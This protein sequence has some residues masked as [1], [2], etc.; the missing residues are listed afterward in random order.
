M[1]MEGA[2][3]SGGKKFFYLVA[4]AAVFAWGLFPITGHYLGA[5]AI[6]ADVANMM[7]NYQLTGE[8]GL[9]KSIVKSCKLKGLSVKPEDVLI[10]E[11]PTTSRVSLKFS[12]TEDVK[13]FFFTKQFTAE[14]ENS[15]VN[16][17]L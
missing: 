12:Y 14:I 3:M 9:R 7:M 15:T 17:G 10:E 8:E 13:I 6:R 5:S 2:G 11:N 16:L 1:S 4:L